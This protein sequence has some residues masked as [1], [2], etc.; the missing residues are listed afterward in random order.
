MLDLKAKICS[1]STL[2]F[3]TDD[4][5][6][7]KLLKQ[8]FFVV[9]IKK[10]TFLS[11][12]DKNELQQIF[13]NVYIIKP[14]ELK[15]PTLVS[16]VYQIQMQLINSQIDQ[17]AQV[18]NT[19]TPSI[20][21][22]NLSQAPDNVPGSSM[23]VT[24]KKG[25]SIIVSHFK[26]D[27]KGTKTL[28]D[29]YSIPQNDNGNK[30]SSKNSETLTMITKLPANLLYTAQLTNNCIL[31]N[32]YIQENDE[33][34]LYKT[35]KFDPQV[36]AFQVQIGGSDLQVQTKYYQTSFPPGLMKVLHNIVFFVA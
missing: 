20:T 6:A 4:R 1:C 2:Q 10:K 21:L 13:D 29:K 16:Q 23:L 19:T 15:S 17:T 11:F 25:S 30:S 26:I 3:T 7:I 36:K 14:L 27:Q 18:A 33:F 35:Y 32:W 5:E 12:V 22:D 9:D 28:L 24:I 34:Y 31:V 8:G